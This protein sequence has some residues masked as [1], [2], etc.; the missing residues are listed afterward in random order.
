VHSKCIVLVEYEA[1]YNDFIKE[2]AA[3]ALLDAVGANRDYRPISCL[4]VL[5]G[6]FWG[7]LLP[8]LGEDSSRAIKGRTRS[9][10]RCRIGPAASHGGF[11]K[12]TAA[13]FGKVQP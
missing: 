13:R 9:A 2:A 5:Q 1:I 4:P 7:A 8:L 3:F 11:P 12:E 10:N 6:S